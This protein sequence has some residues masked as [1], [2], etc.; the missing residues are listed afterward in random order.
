MPSLYKYKHGENRPNR[1]KI[2]FKNGGNPIVDIDIS[3]PTNK[4]DD[5]KEEYL[6]DFGNIPE[7]ENKYLLNYPDVAKIIANRVGSCIEYTKISEKYFEEGETKYP[8]E[9][10]QLFSIIEFMQKEKLIQ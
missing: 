8:K 2:Q 4:K 6:I 9:T 5:Y 10:K 1:C 7:L 3:H